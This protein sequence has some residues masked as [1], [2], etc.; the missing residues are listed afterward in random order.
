M[1][2]E[3]EKKERNQ[4]SKEVKSSST[5]AAPSSGAAVSKVTFF[6][7]ARHVTGTV[8]LHHIDNG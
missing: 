5:P 6:T 7:M 4:L 3:L 8:S 1:S 2:K